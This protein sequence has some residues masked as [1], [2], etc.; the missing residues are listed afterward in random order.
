MTCEQKT[1]VAGLTGQAP[2]YCMLMLGANMGVTR[3]TK[4]HLGLAVNLNLPC[5]VVVTKVRPPPPVTNVC[6]LNA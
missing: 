2:D 3:M 5:F 1:T 4:E 6:H